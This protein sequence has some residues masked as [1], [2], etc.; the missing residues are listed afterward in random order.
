MPFA[1]PQSRK[2]TVAAKKRSMYVLLANAR[3][4]KR[5]IEEERQKDEESSR[6]MRKGMKGGGTTELHYEE[7]Q[8]TGSSEA[9][10]HLS[11]RRAWL[12]L[13]AA[14]QEWNEMCCYT[15]G[16][17]VLKIERLIKQA[18]DRLGVPRFLRQRNAKGTGNEHRQCGEEAL[19]QQGEQEVAQW[20]TVQRLGLLLL[21]T[22]RQDEA[23]DLLCAN[24]YTHR[25]SSEV[26]MHQCKKTPRSK[27][28][29]KDNP[30]VPASRLLCFAFDGALSNSLFED[31]RSTLGE[32]ALFWSEHDYFSRD[33]GF[34]SYVIGVG[35]RLDTYV[36]LVVSRVHELACKSGLVKEGDARYAEWWSHVKPEVGGHELHFDSADWGDGHGPRTPLVS[37][38]L[39]LS[40]KDVGGD[41]IVTDQ[42]IGDRVAQRAVLV[43]PRPNRLA[44]FQGD[45]LHGVV[46]GAGGLGKH[47]TEGAADEPQ[48]E[49]H[50]MD[51]TMSRPRRRLTFMVALWADFK[52]ASADSPRAE[53][54]GFRHP[55]SGAGGWPRDLE[56]LHPKTRNATDVAGACDAA[57]AAGAADAATPVELCIVENVWEVLHSGHGD[58]AGHSTRSTSAWQKQR[59]SRSSSF[60]GIMPW[61]TRAS[62]ASPLS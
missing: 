21:K 40:D 42:R 48:C 61:R 29:H 28:G 53:G 12:E 3:A 41:T 38:V 30:E 45:L 8:G 34:F 46:A 47:R 58:H 15:P 25:L 31:L 11:L 9:G 32:G 60:Q 57:G 14:Q 19:A 24:G 56:V 36:G 20:T 22:G 35:E 62:S 51:H 13:D 17:S 7:D 2:S 54:G 10:S 27:D 43:H 23:H 1:G 18:A 4:W 55:A 5:R 44:M 59:Q 49:A 16:S 50:A 52:F 39:Y 33:R 6:K 37:C 26:L